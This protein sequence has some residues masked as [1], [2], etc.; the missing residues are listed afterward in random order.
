MPRLRLTVFSRFLLFMLIALPV[1]FVA[2]SYY[3][4]EDPLATVRGWLGSDEAV[5]T[6]A[7]TDSELEELRLENTR[8]REELEIC[9]TASAPE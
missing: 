1:I 3:N 7:A 4:G 9:R 2:A 6:A 8:L 5:E